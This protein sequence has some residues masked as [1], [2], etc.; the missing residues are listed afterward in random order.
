MILPN[1]LVPFFRF[2]LGFFELDLPFLGFKSAEPAAMTWV[3][4]SPMPVSL[5]LADSTV[6]ESII[7]AFCLP[8]VSIAEYLNLGISLVG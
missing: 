5:A 8:F 1:P 6:S 3:G 7:P 2:L 4:I